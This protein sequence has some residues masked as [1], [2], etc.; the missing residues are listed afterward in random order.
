MRWL[1]P[2]VLVLVWLGVMGVG[3]PTFGT[4][5]DVTSNSQAD[6]L[7]VDSQ[8]TQV[9]DRLGEFRDSDGIPAIVVME[10][11]G[12]ITRAQLGTIGT[13]TQDLAGV[14]DVLEV[15]PPIPSEDGR[16]VEV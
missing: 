3:G 4:L 14:P 5:S 16:A 6:F 7:P 10:S 15:S 2:V 1:I 13:A 11:Q 9:Q 8:A 12:E